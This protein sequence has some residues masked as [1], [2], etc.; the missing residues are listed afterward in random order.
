MPLSLGL[1]P[2]SGQERRRGERRP[3]GSGIA[4]GAFVCGKKEKAAGAE[5]T[6]KCG[7]ARD[8]GGWKMPSPKGRCQMTRRG[9]TLIELLVVIAI[10]TVLI[11]SA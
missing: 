11:S 6:P 2:F 9:F 7:A 3:L 1:S 10:M 5:K 4:G 8:R